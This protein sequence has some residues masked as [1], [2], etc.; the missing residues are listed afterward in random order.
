MKF[1]TTIL[2][3]GNNTGI[4]VPDDVLAELGGGKRPA[5]NVTVGK[6]TYRSTVAQ[7]GGKN[8]ISL[9]AA[10]RAE[11]G[12]A[13]GDTVEVELTLDTTPR[14]V[15][16]PEDM[17]SILANEPDAKAFFDSLSFSNKSKHVLS[18]TEAKTAETRQRRVEKAMEML[19]AGK[20]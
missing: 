11:S 7:M 3:D 15:D 2:L 12:V 5:V 14:E 4:V 16:V 9:S 8:L 18:I 6:L 13:G 10:R 17:A 1:T 19:R 20:K